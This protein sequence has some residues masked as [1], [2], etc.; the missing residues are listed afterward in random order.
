MIPVF[1]AHILKLVETWSKSISKNGSSALV[2]IQ[3]DLQ[4]TVSL[5]VCL[6][7]SSRNPTIGDMLESNGLLSK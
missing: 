4:R 6:F 2:P 3:A 1:E 5:F 7:V